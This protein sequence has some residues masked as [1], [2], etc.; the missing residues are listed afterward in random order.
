M[1]VDN[2]WL[3]NTCNKYGNFGKQL[4]RMLGLR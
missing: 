4:T 1:K 3:R 2:K